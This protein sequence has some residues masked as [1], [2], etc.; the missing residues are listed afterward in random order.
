MKTFSTLAVTLCFAAGTTFA[1][2]RYTGRL[3]DADCYN[4]NKV[5]TQENGHKTYHNI[6]KTCAATPSTSSFA[7]RVTG[8]PFHADIGN[9]VKLDSEGNAQAMNEMK[10]GALTPDSKGIVKVRVKGDLKGEVLTGA[11]INGRYHK[12][13]AG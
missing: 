3:M 5:S 11:T 6:T 12:H 8:S 9:T 10:N 13:I 7:V 4:S 2:Q 1:A